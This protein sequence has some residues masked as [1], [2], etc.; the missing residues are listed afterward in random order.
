[1][2]IDNTVNACIQSG[3]V[4]CMCSQGPLAIAARCFI[5]SL[6][7]Y[8]LVQR[9]LGGKNMH[10]EIHRFPLLRSVEKA[11]NILTKF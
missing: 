6:G 3:G 9:S 5:K 8:V 4:I 10:V 2:V 11:L 1:M 7:K